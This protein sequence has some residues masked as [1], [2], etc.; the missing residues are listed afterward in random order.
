M[1][2]R[3][4]SH[5]AGVR[6]PR[7]VAAGCPCRCLRDQRRD[8]DKIGV[9]TGMAEVVVPNHSL[10]LDGEEAGHQL[11]IADRP[12]AE[13][14]LDGRPDPTRHHPWRQHLADRAALDA[15]V[16]IECQL[17]I[18]DRSRLRPEIGEQRGA[19][20]N[21]AL[22]REEDSWLR[23]VSPRRPAEIAHGFPRE[24]SAVMA[25][26]DQQRLTGQKLVT[27]RSGL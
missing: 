24:E 3:G 16:P 27:Q 5:N 14:A 18:G 15:E 2:R 4:K 1:R 20:L 10:V 25:Q 8:G 21:R 12:P 19:C 9:V 11:R 23:L 13:V 26:E 22:M 17:G 7:S 6:Q